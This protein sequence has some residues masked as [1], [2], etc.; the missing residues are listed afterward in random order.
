MG[1][2]EQSIGRAERL[3]SSRYETARDRFSATMESAIERAER[4]RL[5]REK[6]KAEAALAAQQAA[7]LERR[8]KKQNLY[9][10]GSI[11]QR[12]NIAAGQAA[13]DFQN[14]MRRD[15]QQQQGTLARDAFQNQFTSQRDKQQAMDQQRRDERQFGYATQQAEQ[16]HGNTLERDAFQNQYATQRDQ[17]QFGQQLQRDFTQFGLDSRRQ[18]QQQRNTLERDFMQGGIQADRDNRLNEF[19][20][21]RDVRQD[22]FRTQDDLRQQQFQ[23]QNM[24]QRETAD[25]AAKWQEQI[26]QA[27]NA[28]LDFSP[29][30]KKEMAELDTAFR[31]NVLNGDLDE[32]T[33]QRAMLLHQKKLSA[34]IPTE[35]VQHPQQ[36]FEQSIVVDQE[37]GQKFIVTQDPN[38]R[39]RYE[40]IGMGSGEDPQMKAQAQA[41]EKQAAA[42]QK[43]TFDR[44]TKFMDMVDKLE[45]QTKVVNDEV[46]PVFSSRQEAVREA[47]NRFAPMEKI[48]RQ[49]GLPPMVEYEAEANQLRQAQENPQGPPQTRVN[50]YRSEAMSAAAAAAKPPVLSSRSPIPP[51]ISKQL[52]QMPGGDQLVKLREK[53]KTNSATDKILRQAADIV[54]NAMLT[55][56]TSDPDYAQALE[57]MQKAGFKIGN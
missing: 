49:Q 12:A 16:Q 26:Q 21:Q 19:D 43:A 31:K 8:D 7:A 2:L 41:A 48:Y 29:A 56:D 20:T 37:T 13:M 34:I 6:A 51:Q 54:M 39:A 28:G 55:G 5:E 57:M 11:N 38:G 50:P 46:V 1:D 27:R 40:P 9:E 23:Q 45:Q 22:R 33:K 25:V 35:Q 36:T 17:T 10:T 15:K 42:M 47:M 32:G 24:Y 18:D 30:Q 14:T 52:M 44:Q 3:R 53:Y 4:R